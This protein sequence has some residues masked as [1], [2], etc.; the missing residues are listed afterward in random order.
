L[1]LE[2]YRF[3]IPFSKP[4]RLADRAYHTREGLI[5]H[6]SIGGFGF[7]AE[8]SPLPGF[9]LENLDDVIQA[10]PLVSESLKAGF[11]LVGHIPS[12]AFATDCLFHAS[13][14]ERKESHIDSRTVFPGRKV[15]IPVNAVVGSSG[16]DEQLDSVQKAY[17][18]GFRT[19]KFKVGI[20]DELENAI[21]R[22]VRHEYPDARIRI[23]ANRGW[24]A[25]KAVGILKSWRHLN[26]EY[27][28]EPVTDAVPEV[29]GMISQESGVPVAADESV[30]NA[31]SAELFIKE[32]SVDY[33]ILKPTLIGQVSDFSRI[34]RLAE[35]A[36]VGVIVTT[37]LESGIGRTW[38]AALAASIRPDKAMGLATGML[39]SNDFTS[40]DSRIENGNYFFDP[41]RLKILEPDHQALKNLAVSCQI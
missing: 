8:A 6:L 29:L 37:S 27:C 3:S 7:W 32:K 2:F 14:L 41:S 20:D 4:F 13:G 15:K 19:F 22:K 36:G 21:L 11:N 17:L 33:L 38:V 30:R 16:Y 39:F 18:S 40:D 25:E 5:I 10:L 12:L 35:L 31:E 1:E 24:D 26:I 23:D 34:C 28:E 9:S